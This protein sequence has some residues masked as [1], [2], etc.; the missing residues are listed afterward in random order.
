M[1]RLLSIVALLLSLKCAS[2]ANEIRVIFNNGF[3]PSQASS[4]SASEM[5]KV[6]ALF[7]PTRRYL[8]DSDI[9]SS[10]TNETSLSSSEEARALT[11][12]SNCK[13]ICQ[14]Y[15]DGNC[16]KNGCKGFRALSVDNHNEGNRNLLTCTEEKKAMHAK[17]DN[18][19]DTTSPSCKN[20]L[21]RS[22]RTIECY[23]D[24]EYGQIEGIRVWT[25]SSSGQTVLNPFVAPGGTVT[26]C[27]SM[28]VN[29]ESLNEPC[30]KDVKL[31]MTG[32]NNY[33]RDHDEMIPP[34]TIFGDDGTIF[35]GKYLP[36][37]GTYNLVLTPDFD[38]AKKKEFKIV[39]NNC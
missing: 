3:A 31:R 9:S 5:D 24:F 6:K 2:A 12:G 29:F 17:L 14:G 25:I 23:A 30:V 32:P 39:V 28:Y 20:F 22:K 7:Q 13:N 4:C 19:R 10:M 26:I 38:P 1:Q 36:H 16:M 15:A 8:R 34:Y 33:V 21:E 18:V 37:S 27:K 11:F 35:N